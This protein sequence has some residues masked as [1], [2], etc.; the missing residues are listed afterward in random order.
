MYRKTCQNK[1]LPEITRY[2][3]GSLNPENR[4]VQMADLVPWEEVEPEYAR[5]FK[6]NGRDE[7]ALN[8]RIAP[9]PCGSETSRSER[10]RSCEKRDRKSV[11]SAPADIRSSTDLNPVNEAR[12]L[13]E[14]V[15]DK[16]REQCDDRNPRPRTKG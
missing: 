7:V 5:H 10:S 4:W 13:T 3:A 16:L 12:E 6:S 11:S 14:S 9:G 8:V 1:E 15:I 2:F